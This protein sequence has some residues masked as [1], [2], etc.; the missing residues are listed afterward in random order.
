MSNNA[1]VTSIQV[2]AD[3]E[4]SDF[5]FYNCTGVQWVYFAKGIKQMDVPFGGNTIVR[6]VY[7]EGT[8]AE[9]DDLW[10]SGLDSFTEVHCRVTRAKL[11]DAV[12][13]TAQERQQKETDAQAV[14]NA[15]PQEEIDYREE[16]VRLANEVRARY[17][18][19]ALK[20]EAVFTVKV[21]EYLES[22]Q[23]ISMN[24]SE[25]VCDM[26]GTVHDESG[27][28]P[29][30]MVNKVGRMILKESYYEI[31]VGYSGNKRIVMLIGF[32]G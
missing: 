8:E 31:G 1:D 20:Q 2:L 17:G 3:A 29:E 7:F 11:I 14:L 19:A 15:R 26:I 25:F 22:G 27:A 21:Q 32:H 10:V 13:K 5:A 30:Q 23:N 12:N 4:I 28:S 24:T 9:W 6:D 18:L 16:V